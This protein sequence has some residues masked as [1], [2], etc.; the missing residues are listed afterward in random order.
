MNK[1][2]FEKRLAE[3][4]GVLW[5]TWTAIKMQVELKEVADSLNKALEKIR[6]KKS[7]K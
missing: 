7:K 6:Q 1:S 2:E 3:G 5:G 4:L